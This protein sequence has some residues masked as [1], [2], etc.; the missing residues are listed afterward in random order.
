MKGTA[1]YAMAS[2]Q[3]F[4]AAKTTDKEVNYVIQ[5]LNQMIV[6]AFPIENSI[7]RAEGREGLTTPPLIKDA[8]DDI[9][10]SD[11]IVRV[12]FPEGLAARL[13]KEELDEYTAQTCEMKYRQALN[14]A[15]KAV[16]VTI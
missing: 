1:I 12:A 8:T 13:W 16:F 4:D 14:D 6:E 7:R 5:F 11:S 15:Q 2:A 9:P 3:L 10:Y